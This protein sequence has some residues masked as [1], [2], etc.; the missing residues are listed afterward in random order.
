MITAIN[1]EKMI[2][3]QNLQPVTTPL[4][5]LGK[6]DTYHPQGLFGEM[7]GEIGTKDRREKMAYID[8][9][10]QVIHP[11]FYDIIAKKLGRKI[12]KFLSQEKY[13][14]IDEQ[15]ILQEVDEENPDGINGF[16]SF[17]ENLDKIRFEETENVERS[18]LIN[19][20]YRNI[21][22]GTFLISKL[23]VISPDFRPAPLTQK[24]ESGMI[25]EPDPINK[26]YQRIIKNANQQKE[27]SGTLYDYTS[28]SIQL[29][30]RDIFEFV[31]IKVSK[32]GG[33]IRNLML[34]KRVDFSASSVIVPNPEAK[35]G[36]LGVPL[37]ICCSIF[38]PFLIYGIMNSPESKH[39]PESF[40]IA[41]KEFLGKESTSGDLDVRT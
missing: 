27:V 20:I 6:S 31:K 35:L 18:K 14:I 22:K 36:Y 41:A 29:L 34:G 38:E 9:N 23:I 7:F 12:I 32:K 24:P 40:H 1:I 11:V 5:F 30:L 33:I 37:R 10:C 28:Y 16:T 25:E 26:I 21:K 8:L 4:I 17:I 3:E 13:Y 15:G 39:I 2:R 19:M